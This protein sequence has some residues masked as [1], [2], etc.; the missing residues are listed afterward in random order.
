MTKPCRACGS[1]DRFPSGP[2]RTCAKRRALKPEQRRE[3]QR[4][5]YSENKQKNHDRVKRWLKKNPMKNREINRAKDHK[6]RGV[7]GKIPKYIYA[8]LFAEQMGVCVCCGDM[9][10]DDYH[11]DHIMPIALGGTNDESNLQ[12]LKA[13]CNMRKGA[14]HPDEWRKIIQRVI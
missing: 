1:E 6:K 4:K 5:W 14:M 13:D 11:L 7:S 12:L 2:C 10:G 8:R 9:L 3:Y